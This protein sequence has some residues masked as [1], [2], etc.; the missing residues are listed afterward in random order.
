MSSVPRYVPNYTVSDYQQWEGDWELWRGIPIAMTPSP[1]GP[2]QKAVAEYSH[3]LISSIRSAEC[4][5]CEV[6]VELDWMV[7]A[8]TVVRPDVAVVCSASL[9]RFIEQPPALI[10]DIVAGYGGEGSDGEV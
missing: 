6:V 2:H 5:G 4:E 3:R 8:H 1:F 9:E 10:I 7:D